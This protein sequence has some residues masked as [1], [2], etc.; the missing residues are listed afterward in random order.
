MHII[1]T[2]KISNE[3]IEIN[4]IPTIYLDKYYECNEFIKINEKAK[5]G[6]KI[7]KNN[8]QIKNQIAIL[9]PEA[10]FEKKKSIYNDRSLD[11]L[12]LNKE[13]EKSRG[14]N[15]KENSKLKKIYE[16]YPL[17]NFKRKVAIYDNKWYFKNIFNNYF[18]FCKGIYCIEDKYF[19][20]CKYYAYLNIIENNKNVYKKENYFFFDFIL[21]KYSADDAYPIFREMYAKNISVHYITEKK[22]IYQKYCINNEKC[23]AII[24]VNDKNYTINGNFLEKYLTLFLKLKQVISGGGFDLDY[25]KSNIFY[26]IDYITYICIT[27]GVSFFKYFLYEINS[28][29]GWRKYDKILIPPSDKLIYFAKIYGWRDENIIKLN[30][31]RWDKYNNDI[32]KY[33]DNDTSEI[34]INS[35]FIMFTWRKIKKGQYLSKFY[36]KNILYLINDK[37]LNVNLRNNNIIL[38][39]T[40]HHKLIYYKNIFIK[41]KYIQF[42]DENKISECLSRTNLVVSDFSSIIFDFIYRRKPFILSIPEAKDPDIKNIYDKNYYEIINLLIN[43][44]ISFENK[45]LEL[46]DVINKIIYYIN[47]NFTLEKNMKRFYDS[48]GFR[49]KNNIIEFI[50]YIINYK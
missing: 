5:L 3:K 11:I 20:K 21:K 31:P 33:N 27:H 40:L 18:C 14:R 37:K 13:N 41:N 28:V 32:L 34:N 29:Y 38:Y 35:I 6:I 39:F 22:E 45:Y 26:N 25:I 30:L 7:Y 43:G 49:K 17:F 36:I 47:N 12:V 15:N 8:I 44:K 16:L 4:S 19:Q 42:L 2:I 50:N 24:Y 9:F 1:C 10:I 23:L 48:F 46:N